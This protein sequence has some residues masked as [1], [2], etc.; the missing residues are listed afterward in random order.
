MGKIVPGDSVRYM[1]STDSANSLF[2]D[3]TYSVRAIDGDYILLM[4]VTGGVHKSLIGEPLKPGIITADDYFDYAEEVVQGMLQLSRKKN[5]D[6]TGSTSDPFANFTRVEALG[7]CSTEQ[8]FLT[9]MTDKLCRIS[10][11][12]K[13]GTL[14]VKDEAVEDTLM[15]LAN[16]CILMMG[17]LRSKKQ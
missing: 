4:G 16:Y 6:Y 7:I 14:E 15:D 8:G 11:F 5:K 3:S 17:Y 13:Q 9:R 2:E 1:G 12:V 10:S